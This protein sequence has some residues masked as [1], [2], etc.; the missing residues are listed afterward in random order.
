[1]AG[2]ISKR[3]LDDIR[4]NNDIVDV[5]GDSVKL[6]RAGSAFKACCPFHKEKTP[7]FHV[8]PQRQIFHCFGCGVGGDVFAFLIQYEGVDFMTAAKMLAQRAGITLELEASA[9]DA[10]VGKDVLY[11]IHEE[12]TAFYQRCLTQME[13]FS[14]ARD[15]LEKRGLEKDVIDEFKIGYA[16][17]G[18]RNLEKWA[19]KYKFSM[20]D[21]ETAGVVLKNDKAEGKQDYYDRFRDRLMFPIFDQQ[22]Q[23]I[24]F[25]GRV[26]SGD[27]KAAKYVNSPETPIFH[28]SRIL[29]ALDKARRHIVSSDMREAIVCE[30]QID[31]IRCHQ[32]GFKTAVASQGTAFTE[33]HA[34]ILNRFADSVVIV[35]DQDKAGQDAAIKVAAIFMEAGM[36]VRVAVLPAGEDPDTYIAEKGAEAFQQVLSKAMS[37]TGF[38]IEVLSGRENTDSEVG[39]M[40][41]ARAVLATVSRCPSAVQRA[42]LIQEAAER[43]SIPASAL[44]EDLRTFLNKESRSKDY[45]E[46]RAMAE[47]KSNDNVPKEE[48]ELCEHLVQAVDSPV[49]IQLLLKFLPMDVISYPLCREVIDATL[50]SFEHGRSGQDIICE[51]ENPSEE[52]KRFAAR[53]QMAPEKLVGAEFSREEAVKDIILRIWRGKLERE[54][55]SL[56][57]DESN[58]ERRNEITYDLK[59]LRT[60]TDGSPI[61]EIEMNI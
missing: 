14:I 12:L 5:V 52:L 32:T 57:N 16:P 61:I 11:R 2:I 15:Y 30:G 49:V 40:R 33:D 18:W 26:M 9:G 17:P 41:T 53:I 59:R 24:G 46:K 55:S 3:I 1:M 35:F 29:Y 51:V 38:Q 31:V 27:E 13:E 8:N 19:Q 60:W 34:R 23:V 56:S 50:S 37:A 44:Q 6:K 21:L 20:E 42:K 36:A 54:R 58:T 25:S 39:A 43:L 10:G 7:S 28:K 22:S 47:I 4:F 45:A 48:M